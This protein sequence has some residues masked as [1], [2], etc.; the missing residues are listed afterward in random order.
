MPIAVIN[1]HG[2]SHFGADEEQLLGY[3]EERREKAE[4]IFYVGYSQ[5][6]VPVMVDRFNGS[7]GEINTQ[8][9]LP[10]GFG[11]GLYD[12]PLEEEENGRLKQEEAE[13]LA[14]TYD[15]LELVGA[16]GSSCVEN[17]RISLEE[18]GANVKKKEEYCWR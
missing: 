10:P 15:R 4:D 5:G 3:L 7:M 18:A 12:G 13:W 8:S 9:R 14:E 11:E 2:F 1:V 16:E 6:R 17:C